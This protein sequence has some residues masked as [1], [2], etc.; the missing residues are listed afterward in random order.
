MKQL[1][2]ALLALTIFGCSKQKQEPVFEPNRTYAMKYTMD[3]QI[4]KTRTN[5]DTLHLDFYENVNLLVDP[6]D[7]SGS[8][9]LIIQEDFAKSNLDKL[10]YWAQA[11]PTLYAHDWVPSNTNDVA[12]GQKTVSNVTVDGKKY[13]KVT[14]ARVF[15]FYNILSSPQAAIDKQN[16]LLQTTTDNVSYKTYYMYNG[17]FSLSNDATLKIA[18]TK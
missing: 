4:V 5:G 13:V 8:W 17:G 9:A 11:T 1:I 6:S 15:E 16:T 7:F 14:I 2:P 12:P 3:D 18:Y 10:E